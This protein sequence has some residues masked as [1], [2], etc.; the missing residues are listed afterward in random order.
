MPAGDEAAQREVRADKEK[1]I[2]FETRERERRDEQA[3]E[4]RERD[5]AAAFDRVLATAEDIASFRVDLDTYDT[6]TVE[7]LMDN[8]EALDVLRGKVDGM[9]DEATVLPDGR[10]AFKTKDRQRVFDEHGQELAPEV[11]DPSSIDSKKPDWETFQASMDERI[12]LTEQRHELS[13]YQAK[14]DE[15][16][17][18]LD[19]G[20]ITAKELKTLKADLAADMPDA[21]RKKLGLNDPNTDA[22]RK[23]E[24]NAAPLPNDM[25]SLMRQ[26]GLGPAPAP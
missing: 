26:T 22:E 11:I 14:L 4:K 19:K 17:E 20:E 21:V 13:T 1:T 23:L 9:L 10:R 6:E 7:A 16:R 2:R 15:A 12:R 5:E 18:R 3:D 25:D 8:Q 24:T